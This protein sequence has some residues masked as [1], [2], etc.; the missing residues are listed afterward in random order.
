MPCGGNAATICG[1]PGALSVYNNTA[2]VPPKQPS[3]VPSV[4]NYQSL[5]CYTEGVNERALTG[6]G[7]AGPDMTVQS[8]VAYC[9]AAGFKYAGIEYSTECFCG[10][11][12]AITA[13]SAPVSECNMLCGG[14][15]YAYCG[16]PNRLNV[17]GNLNGTVTS[18][19]PTSTTTS[20]SVISSVNGTATSTTSAGT[21]S[22]PTLRPG[23]TYLGCANEGT[24]GRALSKD[25][26]ASSTMTT[27]M[28]Q[29][30]C[31]GKG[32]PLSGV[33]YSTE[34]YC[35]SILEN[36]STI[37]GSTACNMQCG[38]AP[39]SICGGPG[40][41]S[42]YNNTAL[43]APRQPAAVPAV[44]NY[45]SQ[46]CYTEGVNERALA[47]SGT[48]NVN[49]TVQL[50]VS[51]CQTGG[52]KYAGIEYSTECFCGSA[53]ATTAKTAPASE[54][55]MLCGGD[56][57]AY[58]GG[59]SRL[60]VYANLNGTTSSP[61]TTSA[62]SST[63]GGSVSGTATTTSTSATT[64][65]SGTSTPTLRAGYTY[66]GCANEG[67]NG[68]AL[69]KDATASS[70]MTTTVC[71][72]YCTGKGYPLSG[73]E[74]STECYCGNVLENGSTIGGSTACTMPCGGAPNSICGGPGALSVYNNTALVVPKQ[75]AVV[76]AV[77][78]Y[79]SQ[80][81]YTEGVNERALAGSGTASVNMTVQSCVSFCQSGGYRYAGIEYS[82][83][84]F[85][86]STIATTAKTA[87]AS[88]CNMLCGGDRLAYC[89]GPSR[90]NVY[91]NMNGTTSSSSTSALATS[92]STSTTTSSGT[93]TSA[94][95]TSKSNTSTT[96][97]GTATPTLRAGYAYLG[98]ANEGTGGRALAKGSTASSTMTTIVCQDYCT[99]KGYPL[100]GI[101]YSTECYCGNSLE[102]GS[103]IGGSTACTM[104]CGGASNLICGGPG[105]LSV[106]NN[107]ALVA[108]KQPAVVPAVGGYGSQGCYTEGANER[109]LAGPGT[110]NVNMT[111]Q[112]CVSYCQ[113]GG[114]KYAGIEYSTECFCGNAIATTAKTAPASEC[115]M[116]CGGDKFAY[117]GG[118]NRLNIY[119]NIN[120][121]TSSS[122]STSIPVTSASLSPTV[123][124]GTT[125]S[126][127]TTASSGT[128]S[129]NSTSTTT[130]T[131][132]SSSAA[133]PTIRPG[134]TY[135]GCAN[136]GT[137]G[138]ALSKAATASSTMTPNVCQDYCT[139]KGYPLSGSEY[140]TE[141]YCGN[142]LENGSSIGGSTRCT[143]P[144]GGSP[145]A[146]CGGPGALSVYN[147]TAITPPKQPIM[148]SAAAGYN[149]TG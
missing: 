133:S 17:Y 88:E 135:L 26:T 65:T 102:N 27:N 70:I 49:M 87:P 121:T 55:N 14:D 69:S 116:L 95:T 8:C 36:G 41:L 9:L 6:S 136:E 54:C 100:S 19:P 142:V 22:T 75:P 53:I 111:V 11:S 130:T 18:V 144:C 134:Y 149:L 48:A 104:P 97:S 71:Q 114:Y 10:A 47:G 28:C 74:Y 73:V 58:C 92:A 118:P 15:K 140:S 64:S 57:F 4:G 68:R 115:N 98:C 20:T 33:E 32:Y 44:G 93:T 109:A 127:G 78:N 99:G 91:Q 59:P 119:G 51:Y 108:P 1:G 82:T 52:Y 16:G 35:G 31:T 21:S 2:L 122:S 148:I 29:D 24:S 39:N 107:T 101:E 34:C 123:A 42:V 141:C 143:M 61:P 137:N 25:A 129:K 45:K 131:G 125:T 128:T 85:C 77:G 103:T 86:G 7:T 120:G 5:G 50:C 94:S 126:T 96:T 40:A 90:L 3:I 46:G 124:S 76:P 113:I 72:D 12:I 132:S 37:G 62:T 138:R 23:Y 81:C 84:C 66:L 117:C 30:Y 106:Y 60:N 89:G 112:S 147:N 38:G 110:A 105:A 83:E 56:Q 67:T 139:S 13:K 146:I 80:G 145:S 43:V 63:T 79:K